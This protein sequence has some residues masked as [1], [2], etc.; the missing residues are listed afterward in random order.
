[1]AVGA[2]RTGLYRFS[3]GG[4][5]AVKRKYEELSQMQMPESDPIDH[6]ALA[7][8]AFDTVRDAAQ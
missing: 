7:L 2:S 1:M 4:A 8:K 3:I 5:K 6:A